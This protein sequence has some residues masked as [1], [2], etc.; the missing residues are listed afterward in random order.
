[1]DNDNIVNW[2]LKA[3]AWSEI[4]VDANG[5]DIYGV[6]H[7][8]KGLR[9]ISFT[10]NGDIQ[11]VYADG[12]TVYTGKTN[13]GYGGSM[14]F[15][16]PDEDFLAFVLGEVVDSNGLQYEIV[17]PPEKRVAL[18]WEWVGDKRHTRHCMYNCTITRPELSVITKGDGGSKTAQYQTLNIQAIPRVNDDIVKVRT[19][20]DADASVYNGWFNS[21][22]T[23]AAVGNQKVTVTVKVST[24]PIPGAL[25]QLSNGAQGV[26][27]ATGTIIFYLPAGTYSAA[28]SASGYTPKLESI[29]VSN[30]AVTKAITLTA[31]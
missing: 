19:R 23:I 5:N 8:F 31:A 3:S 14:E 27:D 25:I 10:P 20:S 16:N 6:P 11:K 17:E 2:G 1:M 24:T 15:T 18:L 29:T 4:S 28:A 9:S 7:K 26:T 21:V 30:S 22:P 13:D 12:T